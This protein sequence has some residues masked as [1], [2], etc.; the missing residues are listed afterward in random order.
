MIG[1]QVEHPQYGRGQVMALYRNGTEWLVR[2]DSGLR[3]RRPRHEFNGQ[4]AAVLPTPAAPLPYTPPPPMPRSQLAARHLIEALRVGVAPAQHV[5]ELTIG[6]AEER[7]S[8]LDGL[9]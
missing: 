3:F 2:F 1:E 6:L 4:A 7:R 5:Q 8:L 9:N